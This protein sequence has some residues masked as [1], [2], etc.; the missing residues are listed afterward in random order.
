MRSKLERRI[1]DAQD[2]L[3]E[4]RDGREEARAMLLL[5]VRRPR[6][7][8][9]ASGLV[10]F[11]LAAAMVPLVLAARG[12]RSKV[13]HESIHASPDGTTWRAPASGP[14]ESAESSP[15]VEA[16]ALA[17]SATSPPRATVT[18][19]SDHAL[20][21]A[22][23]PTGSIPPAAPSA[24][25]AWRPLALSGRYREALHE[26][27]AL[28]FGELCEKSSASDLLL[29]GNAARFGGAL[30]Q[31][32]Q[33][34]LAIRERFPNAPERTIAT[35]TLGRIAA[36]DQ[37]DDLAAAHWFSAMLDERTGGDLAEEAHGRLIES[38][39]RG[40][41]HSAARRHAT[42]YLTAF[43]AGPHASMARHVLAR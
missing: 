9:A 21:P 29:L 12:H 24:P 16:H 4:Q 26:A 3:L 14:Q 39:E 1:A 28:G 6:R 38:L 10:A 37:H 32:K 22:V 27:D 34:L 20:V 36:D 5:S 43:P 11:A 17:S 30:D 13:D 31:S 7:A 33:A 2:H 15:A 41:D 23:A 19:R 40:G 18:P 25:P 35:F 8:R 42:S